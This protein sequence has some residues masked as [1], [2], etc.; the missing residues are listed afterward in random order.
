[1]LLGLD[2][3]AVSDMLDCKQY[4]GCVIHL[5]STFYILLFP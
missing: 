4:D 1:M 3:W 5:R 2:Q